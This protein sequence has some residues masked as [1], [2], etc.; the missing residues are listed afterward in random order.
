MT[1][2]IL[3]LTADPADAK[4]LADVLGR[5]GDASLKVDWVTRLEEGIN[6]LS[7]GG[8]DAVLAD[9]T[10]EDSQGIETFDRLYA[11]APQI[12]ILPLVSPHEEVL[13]T[14]AVQRGAQGYLT[15]G[16]F[17]SYLVPLFLR[18]IILRKTLETAFWTEKARAEI[19]LNSIG[20]AVIGT[21][22][23]GKVEYLNLAAVEMTGWQKNEARGHPITEIL[24][25]VN[26]VTREHVVNPVESVLRSKEPA[27]LA[28]NTI[29]VRRDGSE[30]MI[31]DSTAPIN[32][33]NGKIVGTVMV[34]RDVTATQLMMEK[35]AHHAQHDYLTDLPN[36]LL[37]NDRIEREIS[38]ARRRDTQLAVLFLDLDNFK[39]INDSLGHETGDKLLQSVAKRLCACVRVS[40]TVS[41][42]GGDEFV[43]LVSQ[44]NGGGRA[45]LT[46]DKVLA[47]MT[48]PHLING[49]E[50][51]ITTSIGISNY[52]ED[53]EN[54]ETLIKNADTAMYQAKEN[55]RNNYQFFKS[56][57]NVR[58]VER[59]TIETGLRRA[60]ERKE[61]VLHYQ[62]KVNLD[63]RAVSGAEAL[64]RWQHP[65]RGLMLPKQFVPIA[66]DCGLIVPIGAWVLREA[67]LQT[68]RWKNV[69][70]EIDSIAVNISAIEFRH[71]GFIECIRTILADTG[72]RPTC[73]Q[74]EITESVLMHSVESSS[75]I[76]RQI[77]EMG[78]KI[79]VDDFGTGYSSLS[80]LNQFPIDVLKI[81]Q[82][83]VHEISPSNGGAIVSAIIAMGASL[84]Q[85]VVAEGIEEE[86]QLAFLR[87]MRCDEGQGHL[88][89][90]PLAAEEFTQMMQQWKRQH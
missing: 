57:M 29:L 8:I 20:D 85:D 35:M 54:A 22:M 51:H 44:V 65:E 79:A 61:L 80:Y 16:D 41:R 68:Q 19:T 10:L 66:E 72:L 14:E 40:D 1:N 31:K 9:L 60:L 26:G 37:L 5:T 53:G 50:M 89:S 88:F 6:R 3:I 21:D 7:L 75:T 59:Q 74:L 12:P 45:A 15:K 24:Q 30:L 36:R 18:D 87:K 27:E 23:S 34:F 47:A 77:K 46:A 28:G 64:L 39:N 32:D 55:G 49:N 67:C 70:I 11:F 86:R 58:V 42:Q 81:D 48:L 76:L 4:T 17:G 25:I 84:N 63:T 2:R 62:P 71:K 78:V 33:A 13:A 73:L 56:E 52:P 69:G 83:F 38:Y 90:R 82:S 43:L